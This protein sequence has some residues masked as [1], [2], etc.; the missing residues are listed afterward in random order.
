MAQLA[1]RRIPDPKAGSSSLSVLTIY[2]YIYI[3]YISFF[4]SL[5]G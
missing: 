2:I 3:Y 5:V 1:A 4:V